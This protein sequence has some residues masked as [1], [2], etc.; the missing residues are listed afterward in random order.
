MDC[1]PRSLQPCVKNY[2]LWLYTLCS[3]K[4][5]PSLKTWISIDIHCMHWLCMQ[6]HQRPA[7]STILH[8]ATL[9]SAKWFHTHILLLAPGLKFIALNEMKDKPVSEVILTVVAFSWTVFVF[10]CMQQGYRTSSPGSHSHGDSFNKGRPKDRSE[11]TQSC[12]L[13]QIRNYKLLLLLLFWCLLPCCFCAAVMDD[14]TTELLMTIT[15]NKSQPPA[16]KF[17]IE[18]SSG[19]QVPLTFESNQEQVTAWLNSKG[20]SKP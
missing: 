1:G 7:A 12:K 14:V 5:P 18:R 2:L 13:S 4:F 16:R 19:S 8:G 11:S 15:A 17:R 9:S 10:V 6:A 3:Y 20:F